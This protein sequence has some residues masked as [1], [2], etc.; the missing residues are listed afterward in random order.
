MGVPKK[1]IQRLDKFLSTQLGITRSEAKELIKRRVVTVGGTIAKLF[2]MKID[3]ERDVVCSE[4]KEVAYRKHIYIMMNKPQGVVCSTRDGESQTVLELLPDSIRREGL[5]P[6][7]RLDKDTEGFVFITDDGVLA[8]NILSPKRHVDKTYFARLEKP[9]DEADVKAFESGMEI[10]G[11]D[12]CLPARLEILA[13]AHEVL[14]TIR[15]GMYHQIKRMAQARNN[16]V[17]YLKRLSIGNVKLD[18]SLAPGE[19]REMLHKEIENI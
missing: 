9:A 8:H 19:W 16:K 12:V 1:D 3:P 17:L 4:G 14:I 6:A 18:E 15:E 5:F 2:D 13:D 10:D 11:G 7:G